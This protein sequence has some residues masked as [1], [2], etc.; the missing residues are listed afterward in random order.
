VCFGQ[1][2]SCLSLSQCFEWAPEEGKS[3]PKKKKIKSEDQKKIMVFS[4][5]SYFLGKEF[6]LQMFKL[7]KIS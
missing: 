7:R 4:M 3:V 1:H 5:H 6:G 2:L